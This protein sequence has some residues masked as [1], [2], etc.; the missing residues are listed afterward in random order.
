MVVDDDL[1]MRRLVSHILQLEGYRVTQ[2]ASGANALE[3]V[4][5]E[6]PDLV[7]LDIMMPNIDGYEVLERLRSDSRLTALP[8]IFLSALGDAT[9]IERGRKLGVDHY[10]VKPFAQKQLLSTVSGTLRRYAELRRAW[11]KQRPA[12]QP[13]APADFVPTGV[14]PVDD[15]VGGL[16]RGHVYLALGRVGAAKSVL[17]IQFLHAGLDRGEGAVLITTDRLETVLYVASSVGLDLRPHMRS[18]RLVVLGLADRF[19]YLLET[20]EDIAGVLA[21]VAAHAAT[22]GATRIAVVSILTVLCSTP[23]LPLSAPVMTDLVSGLERT[24]ATTLLVSDEPVTHQEELAAAYLKRTAFGT[25]VLDKGP[26]GSALGVVRLERM[27]GT[28]TEPRAQAFRVAH[29]VGLVSADPAAEPDVYDKLAELRH[30]IELEAASA[31]EGRAGLVRLVAGGYRL[32]D[33]F[34]LFLRECLAAALRVTEQCA[35]L[36]VRFEM[37]GAGDAGAEL[38]GEDLAGLL[39]SQEILCWLHPAEIVILALGADAGHAALLEVRL[40]RRLHEIATRRDGRLAAF[41]ATKAIY[42]HGGDTVEA[43]LDAVGHELARADG[44]GASDHLVA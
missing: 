38:S 14:G 9:S 10:L 11:T 5:R 35:L 37:R 30:R 39:A 15:Q 19:E 21:E 3:L 22:C 24:G 7:V 8:V 20:R 17:A 13:A 23:R 33:A 26:G 4:Q 1:E 31:E 43:L 32:G 18:G 29:G 6:V 27:L 16:S 41:Q 40:R 28:A 44:D 12:A 2:A 25:I 36:V 42:P 34:A